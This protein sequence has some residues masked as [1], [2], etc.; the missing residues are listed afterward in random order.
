M[1]KFIPR[2][3]KHKARQREAATDNVSA[4]TNQTQLLPQNQSER[5]EKRRKLKEELRAG[6]GKISGKKQKRLDKYIDTKLKKDENLELLRKLSQGKFDTSRLRSS[7][8]LGKRNFADFVGGG[9]TKESHVG[10]VGHDVAQEPTDS[11]VDS[12]DSFE[13]EHPDTFGAA[14]QDPLAAT[15]GHG[16]AVVETGSGL[17]K[18]L[19]LGAGGVPVL[20]VRKKK[21][22]EP[23]MSEPEELP[24][25]GFDSESEQMPEDSDELLEEEEEEEEDTEG[26]RTDDNRTDSPSESEEDNDE[27]SD[28]SD[29]SRGRLKPRN[30]AFKAWAMQQ[31]NRS[32]DYTPQHMVDVSAGVI[33]PEKPPVSQQATALTT[34]PPTDSVPTNPRTVYSVNVS[35]TSVIQDARLG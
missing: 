31:I 18:P 32:L 16:V 14:G 26:E 20:Q 28:I 6:Q 7:K 23:N 2:Q 12:E 35:R 17:R 24:W 5:D 34:Q 1:P 21:R 30:S 19:V 13:R 10:Q 9:S 29:T 3:R 11:D 8:H 33:A 4:N 25:E 15:G 22:I 27:D